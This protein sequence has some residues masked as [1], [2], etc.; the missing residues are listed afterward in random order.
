MSGLIDRLQPGTAAPNERPRVI[1]VHSAETATVMDAL[2]S[3]TRRAILDALFDEP[4]TPS[5]LASNLDTSAQNVHYHLSALREAGLIESVGVR[6][7][8]KGNE[9]S[10]YAPANDPIVLVGDEERRA[11]VGR[12]I[13]DLLAGLGVLSLAALFVQWGAE[14][15]LRTP[16][17]SGAVEPAAWDPGSTPGETVGWLVFD[18]VEPGVLFFFGCLLIIALVAWTFD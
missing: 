11:R 3:E 2:S 5:A 16:T 14:R 1:D 17:G 13:Q 8:E 9:M 10:V 7:S 6:Y 12:S 4:A 18:V 15:L